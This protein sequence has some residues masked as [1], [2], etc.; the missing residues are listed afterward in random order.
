MKNRNIAVSIILSIITC[1]IYTIYWF[2]VCTDEMNQA[3]E[4][5]YK[6]SGIAA[7]LLTLV[8]CGIY[9]IYWA[10]K[11]GLKM[12]VS[13]NN[14]NGNNHILA[15]ILELFGLNIVNLCLIQNEINKYASV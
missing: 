14:P 5:D 11:M 4:D 10:Y 2:V 7:F 8:T 13:Q 15:L 6:T 3:I 12:N 1:G 9:G